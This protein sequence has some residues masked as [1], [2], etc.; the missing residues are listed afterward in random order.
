MGLIDSV[1][2]DAKYCPSTSELPSPCNT[3]T[4]FGTDTT[5]EK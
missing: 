5:I 3:V 4:R 2:A 1:D